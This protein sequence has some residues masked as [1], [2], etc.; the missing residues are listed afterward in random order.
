[1]LFNSLAFL[2]FFPIVLLLHWITPKKY[3]WIVLLIA[4]YFFYM[5]WNPYLVILILGTT[6]VSYG[7]AILIEKTQSLK[8]KKFILSICLIVCLGVLFFFKYFNFLSQSVIDLLKLFGLPMSEFSLKLLLPVGISFYTFQTLSYTIDVYRGRIK[9]EKHF[10]YYALFVSFFPQLVAGPIERP[11]NL[12]PQL[13]KDRKLD[14]DDLTIGAKFILIGF[15]KKVIIADSIA[16]IVNSVYNNPSEATGLSV[17]IA[18]ILFAVQILCDF[19][20]YTNI[21]I[22]VSKT[23]GIDLMQNFNN[24]YGART[25]KEFWSRWHISLS[26]WFRDYLYIPLG[27]NRCKKSRH[28]FNLFITFLL[29][30]LWHG[31][32]W[33]FVIWGALHGLYQIIGI[34]TNKYRDKLKTR[35]HLKST[36]LESILQRTSTF[37]LVCFAWLFFRANSIGD[38]KI[39]LTKLFTDWSLSP[40]VL[41]ESLQTIG[42]AGIMPLFIIIVFFMLYLISKRV[43]YLETVRRSNK[44]L[45]RCNSVVD[46]FFYASLTMIVTLGWIWLAAQTGYSNEFIYFQF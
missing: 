2:L 45:S 40:I 12:L 43:D 25:I 7:S 3:R 22:G 10:G 24:P 35:I 5:S 23:M 41:E 8:L 20:G 18:T 27:G 21:A 11:D 44:P 14:R 13:K 31:A 36:P 30:G 4:S 28:L 1:M 26:T 34:L 17:L 15:F 29:S 33:T 9:A 38:C 46:V 6:I 19:D 37:A 39:L 16:P 42:L 32:N